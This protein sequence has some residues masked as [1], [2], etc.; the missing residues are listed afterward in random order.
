MKK[1]TKSLRE[2]LCGHVRSFYGGEK[3]KKRETNKQKVWTCSK[4][5]LKWWLDPMREALYVQKTRAFEHRWTLN[6]R[7]CFSS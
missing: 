5:N 3:V 4:I 2:N 7:N 6:S 1:N